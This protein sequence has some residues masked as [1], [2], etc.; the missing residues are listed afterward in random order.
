MRAY[1]RDLNLSP[2]RLSEVLA[3]KNG[4]STKSAASIAKRI[5]L[6]T[7]EESWFCDLV[8][9]KH[10]RS[11]AHRR[12]AEARV[13]TRLASPKETL[14]KRDEFRFIADW[15]FLALVELIGTRGFQSKPA[16]IAKR[17]GITALAAEDAVLTLKRLGIIADRDGTLRVVGEF[18]TTTDSVP[19]KAIRK[20][21]SQMILKAERA[22]QSQP[23]E[24][25]DISGIV[26]PVATQDLPLVRKMIQDF[27]RELNRV[28]GSTS[29]SKDEVYSLSVQFFRL[30]EKE[31]SL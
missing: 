19:S 27:R 7:E 8:A 2:S 17:L 23:V 9:A 4:F 24:E 18:R 20:Y 30:S 6:D 16:W 25:R 3:R 26:M 11:L 13:R 22:L 10:A 5:D 31:T 1:A 29:P 15:Y 28:V 14:L 12:E 21:H